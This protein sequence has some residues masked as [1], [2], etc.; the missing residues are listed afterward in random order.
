MQTVFLLGSLTEGVRGDTYIL[1][2][3]LLSYMNS[4]TLSMNYFYEKVTLII[5]SI[6][7]H[8]KALRIFLFIIRETERILSR[9]IVWLEFRD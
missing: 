9:T 2:N 1:P 4:N 5:H 3:T 7:C 8:V 6:M